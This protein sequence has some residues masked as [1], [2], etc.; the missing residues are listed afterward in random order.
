MTLIPTSGS[1]CLLLWAIYFLFHFLITFFLLLYVSS[2][3]L[4][5]AIHFIWNKCMIMFIWFTSH[6]QVFALSWS[7]QETNSNGSELHFYFESVHF[8]FQKS[9]GKDLLGFLSSTWLVSS[10]SI[11]EHSERLSCF[12]DVLTSALKSHP[13][14]LLNMSTVLMRIQLCI[15]SKILFLLGL[16]LRD[17]RNFNSTLKKLLRLQQS[18]LILKGFQPNFSC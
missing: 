3:F 17:Y 7:N 11:P 2:S 16:F 9:Q 10:S 5:K 14:W 13:K 15:W 6:W 8:W 12:S 4:S 1:E 18:T